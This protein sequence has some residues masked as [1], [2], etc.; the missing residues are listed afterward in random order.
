MPEKYRFESFAL[1]VDKEEG[2]LFSPYEL[3]HENSKFDEHVSLPEFQKIVDIRSNP[4]LIKVM[5]RAFKE[6]PGLKTISL[7]YDVDLGEMPLGEAI[8]LRRSVRHFT[9]ET[10]PLEQLS[11]LLLYSNGIT[12]QFTYA[13]RN[14]EIQY[15]RAAP[16]AGALYPIEIY[17]VILHV[18]GDRKSVV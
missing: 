13:F 10:I 2:S 7:P 11:A 18:E 12:G 9:G 3:F 5:S 17:P 4:Q 1:V 8:R 14:P 15:L 6:Y 16:S